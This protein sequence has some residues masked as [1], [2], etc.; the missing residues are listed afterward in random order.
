MARLVGKSRTTDTKDSC[1]DEIGL[2][3][4]NIDTILHSI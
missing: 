4:Q 1:F 2:R 3:A